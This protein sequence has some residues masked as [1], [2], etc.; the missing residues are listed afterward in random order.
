MNK[1]ILM[2]RLKKMIEKIK[3]TCSM[4]KMRIIG[5]DFGKPGGDH[6]AI[7]TIKADQTAAGG[8]M[9][10]A[11]IRVSA[12]TTDAATALSSLQKNL[13]MIKRKET[14]NWRKMHRLPMR[15]RKHK[16]QQWAKRQ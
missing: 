4:A 15:R 3:A 8:E 16:R 9:Q 12:S 2:G 11:F 5:I 13:E 10:K 7:T 14:N 6:T 1:V